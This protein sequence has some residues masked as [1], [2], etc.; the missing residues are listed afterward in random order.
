MPDNKWT[1]SITVAAQRKE[2]LALLVELEKWDI[3]AFRRDRNTL[4]KTIKFSYNHKRL[5]YIHDSLT[6]KL[7][8]A[9]MKKLSEGL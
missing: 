6:S 2:S 9:M 1:D 3:R 5:Q 7:D 4:I 8:N